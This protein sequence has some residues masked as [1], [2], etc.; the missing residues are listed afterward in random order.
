M[1][2]RPPKAPVS[3][4]ALTNDLLF[5]YV[6]STK[7]LKSV[8]VDMLFVLLLR[9]R[10]LNVTGLINFE[11]LT[12]SRIACTCKL[13]GTKLDERFTIRKMP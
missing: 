7:L 9:L 8:F 10:G 12:F 5:I 3:I 13:A 6:F 11:P 4:D 2:S 1:V